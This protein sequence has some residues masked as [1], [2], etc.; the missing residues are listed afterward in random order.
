MLWE[1]T[2]LYG[3]SILRLCSSYC[4]GIDLKCLPGLHVSVN[5]EGACCERLLFNYCHRHPCIPNG[6]Y[7]AIIPPFAVI[8]MVLPMASFAMLSANTFVY[9]CHLMAAK[10]SYEHALVQVA[11]VWLCMCFFY[12][13]LSSYS[14]LPSH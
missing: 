4:D 8:C 14:M 12:L 7:S 13:L 6:T 3:A 10:Q 2:F 9:L 1:L 5:N 11:Y